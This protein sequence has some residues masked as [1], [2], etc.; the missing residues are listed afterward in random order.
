[1][2]KGLIAKSFG[3]DLS[4]ISIFA[5]HKISFGDM[6]LLDRVIGIEKQLTVMNFL[7]C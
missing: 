6:H 2:L 3:V 7:V 1:M 4:I 5:D